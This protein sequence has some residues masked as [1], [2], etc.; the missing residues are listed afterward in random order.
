M[1]HASLFS[2]IGGAEIAATWV[3]WTNLFHC[4]INPFCRNVL[5]YWFPDSISYGDIKKTDFTSWQGKIDVLSGGFPCQPFSL[6]GRRKGTEDDRYLFPEMLRAITEIQP[7]WVV[8]ENVAG[9]ISMVQPG[10]EADLGTAGYLFEENHLYRKEQEYVLFNIINSLESVGYEVQPI[11]IPACA[12]GAPHRRD[13]IWIIAHRT[14]ARTESQQR[15]SFIPN[16]TRSTSNTDSNRLRFWQGKSFSQQGCKKKANTSCTCEANAQSAA[17]DSRNKGWYAIQNDDGY[18]QSTQQTT[19]Q[20]L[21]ADCAQNWWEGFPSV[22][23]VCR[24][25]DGLP[26]DISC[27]TISESKWRKETIKALGNAWVPQVA[28]EIFRAIDSL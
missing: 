28:Y 4:E 18:S 16:A 5:E 27:L 10:K 2:G 13:R 3:G 17:I 21:G 15:W 8:G 11:V 19:L 22:S 6:A 7:S 14:D 1:T 9:L 20:P 24:G 23:P 26:F 12:V 25:N